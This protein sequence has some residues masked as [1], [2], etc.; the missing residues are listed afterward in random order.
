MFPSTNCGSA[1]CILCLI[2]SY[3]R[4]LHPSLPIDCSF[5]GQGTCCFNRLPLCP[6]TIAIDWGTKCAIEIGALVHISGY[7]TTHLRFM[8]INVIIFVIYIYICLPG[9]SIFAANNSHR[10]HAPLRVRQKS[11]ANQA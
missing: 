8:I 3:V 5:V 6:L 10:L 9:R 2:S 1:Q 4:L 7:S 11:K